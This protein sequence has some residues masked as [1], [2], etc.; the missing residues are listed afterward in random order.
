MLA[1]FFYGKPAFYSAILGALLVILPQLYFVRKVFRCRG[2]KFAKTILKDFYTG[3]AIKM[4]LTFSGFA[5]IFASV[6]SLDVPVFMLTF[7]VG[8]LLFWFSPLLLREHKKSPLTTGFL[9]G[10]RQQSCSE[11][12][13]GHTG[14]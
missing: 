12:T 5:A 4:L 13:T 2:A 3:E 14:K 11:S 9:I 1:L 10:R 6:R 7:V 8:Q